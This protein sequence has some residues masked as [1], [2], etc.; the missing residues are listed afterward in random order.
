MGY[1]IH[2]LGWQENERCCD[3][4]SNEIKALESETGSICFSNFPNS[5]VL[6]FELAA[7]VCRRK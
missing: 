1:I 3:S 5:F 4:K 2:W 6:H 7:A